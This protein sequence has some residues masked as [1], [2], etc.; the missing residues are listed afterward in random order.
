[1]GVIVAL[2]GFVAITVATGAALGA[3]HG[4]LSARCTAD[5]KGPLYSV[6]GHST[7]LYAI[8]MQG[9]SCAFSRPW[10]VKLVSQSRL[11]PVHGP[12]GWT[13]IAVSKTYSPIAAG[14]VCGP[15]KFK[16]PTVPAKGFNW[17]P[18]VRG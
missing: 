10:V 5:V 7:H 6:G 13:C 17:Y 9:V 1:L 3:S 11:H 2:V 8:E 18:D 16:L 4:T 12:A 15:G 14:V